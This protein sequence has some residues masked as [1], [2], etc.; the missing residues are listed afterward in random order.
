MI[1]T[2]LTAQMAINIHINTISNIKLFQ[3]CEDQFLVEVMMKL[4]HQT[5]SPGDFIFQKGEHCRELLIVKRGQLQA[6]NEYGQSVFLINE[7]CAFGEL[8]LVGRRAYRHELT[9]RSIGYSDVFFLTKADLWKLFDDYP[10]EKARLCA[11]SENLL[12]KSTRTQTRCD[13]DEIQ[14]SSIDDRLNEILHGIEMLERIVNDNF[15]NY[16]VLPDIPEH[17]F[18]SDRMNLTKYV[19]R[20]KTTSDATGN[21]SSNQS[22]GSESPS[23]RLLLID[24]TAALK[25]G[26]CREILEKELTYA[27]V[28]KSVAFCLGGCRAGTKITITCKDFYYFENIQYASAQ[29]L[30]CYR[31]QWVNQQQMVEAPSNCLPGCLALTDFDMRNAT[32]LV[33][34]PRYTYQNHVYWRSG[35]AFDFAPWRALGEDEYRCIGGLI[36]WQRKV[37]S[38]IPMGGSDGKPGICKP[39]CNALDPL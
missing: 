34:P 26:R 4:K 3:G 5:F 17:F 21:D 23:G 22:T 19:R 20:N 14:A 30:T 1:P 13:F 24:S 27:V 10:N 15:E 28:K 33:S 9:V 39:L 25:R 12:R 16:K 29:T 38:L 36:G 11:R 35:F 18:F 7:D 32:Y 6:E 31:G 37:Q 2:R 8:E